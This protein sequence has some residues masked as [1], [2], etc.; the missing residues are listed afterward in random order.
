MALNFSAPITVSR[1][2]KSF[3]QN[4]VLDEMSFKMKKGEIYSLV[5]LNGIGKTTIIKIIL[6]LLDA[7]EGET[8]IFD[9]TNSDK[10][11]K[12]NLTYLPE[13]FAP[14]TF[15]KG[16]E[17]LALSCSY[18]GKKYNKKTAEEI[19]EKLNFDP[20]A[21]SRRVGSYSKGMG[22]KL[23][24]VSVFLS[25]SPLLILDEPMS[26]LDPSAR[27]YLKQM[28]KQYRDEGNSIF[29]TSHILADIEEICDRIGILHLGKIYYEGSVSKFIKTYKTDN[30][31]QAFLRAIDETK[32]VI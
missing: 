1:V 13:K 20:A 15:L 29:F 27:I 11:A 16:H 14:S 12:E 22:Q 2:K 8:Q 17:F 19:C 31:E 25:K 23:G 5:G 3:K 30:L 21:L 4:L 32:A 24:L 7:D 6:G 9:R 18:Y 28:L 26:G 10:K